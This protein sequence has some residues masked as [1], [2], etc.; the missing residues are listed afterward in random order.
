MYCT[1]LHLTPS[2]L[3]KKTQFFQLPLQP[4]ARGGDS[5]HSAPL[6]DLPM[7]LPLHLE[8]GADLRGSLFL[9]RCQSG[10]GISEL[11]ASRAVSLGLSMFW[12]VSGFT[13]KGLG[14]G[15]LLKNR[16]CKV[17]GSFDSTKF[18]AC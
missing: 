12:A 6:L 14:G 8:F 9:S 4:S 18:N 3:F 15:S 2:A 11:P 5:E 10:P 1:P 16:L 17:Q 13:R 7:H